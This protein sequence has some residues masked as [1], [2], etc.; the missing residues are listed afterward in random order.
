M[1]GVARTRRGV[2]DHTPF[3]S[4]FGTRTYLETRRPRSRKFE[5][6]HPARSGTPLERGRWLCTSDVSRRHRG[7]QRFSGLPSGEGWRARAGVCRIARLRLL[8][9]STCTFVETRRPRRVIQTDTLRP[10]AAYLP[11]CVPVW[12]F[13]RNLP[14]P[15]S[16]SFRVGR[17]TGVTLNTISV[18]HHQSQPS[19]ALAL[20]TKSEGTTVVACA[21]MFIAAAWLG[22]T[23]SDL[24]YNPNRTA[25]GGGVTV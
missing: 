19:I 7:E 14:C 12:C 3:F 9:F 22:L 25:S 11:S 18:M 16:L 2:S 8:V 21:A 23:P 5:P 6:T 13:P 4:A 1:R 20:R 15:P 17:N 24:G 10:Q